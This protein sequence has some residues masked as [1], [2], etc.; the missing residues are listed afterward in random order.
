M[1][2]TS[3]KCIIKLNKNNFVNLA[4]QISLNNK[5]Y[6]QKKNNNNKDSLNENVNAVICAEISIHLIY[7]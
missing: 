6:Q 5:S 1:L 4:E 2:N 7:P 3:E